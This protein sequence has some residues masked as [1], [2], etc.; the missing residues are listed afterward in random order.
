MTAPGILVDTYTWIEISK[1]SP[2]GRR[3]LTWMEK[4]PALFV[5]VL[6]LYEL[7]YRFNDLYGEKKTG[8]FIATIL[9]HA[10]VIPIDQQIATMAG[11]IK[12]REKKEGCTMGSVDCM[13]LATAR[14]HGLKILSGDN[15]F[16]GFE[17]CLKISGT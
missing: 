7:Q 3:A 17:E 13:I 9:N 12:S 5:S 15:H 11:V 2:W 1:N 6:T 14:V 16:A 4:R 8:S 10:D